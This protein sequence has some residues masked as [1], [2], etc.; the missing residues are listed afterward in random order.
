M[1]ILI[2]IQFDLEE[3]PALAVKIQFDVEGLS[4]AVT[5]KALRRH[6]AKDSKLVPG[7]ARSTCGK[8]HGTPQSSRWMDTIRLVFLS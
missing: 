1:Y 7:A 5:F 3:S 6:Y 8:E 4:D 2:L